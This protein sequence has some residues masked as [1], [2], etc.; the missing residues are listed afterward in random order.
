MKIPK[1]PYGSVTNEDLEKIKQRNLLQCKLLFQSFPIAT[2]VW[3]AMKAKVPLKFI[4][5]NWEEI[6]KN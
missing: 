4:Q 5:D 1:I 3:L 6:T 2:K